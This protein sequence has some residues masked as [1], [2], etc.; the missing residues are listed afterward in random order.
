M[1]VGWSLAWPRT[2]ARLPTARS[3]RHRHTFTADGDCTERVKETPSGKSHALK[4]FENA[5]FQTHL[6]RNDHV[7]LTL[8][9]RP[10]TTKEMHW[11]NSICISVS[12]TT[13]LWSLT[14]VY[15]LVHQTHTGTFLFPNT[16]GSPVCTTPIG[17]HIHSSKF[18][19]F[20]STVRKFASNVFINE[21]VL[22]NSTGVERTVD[23]D[24]SFHGASA[25]C[26]HNVYEVLLRLEASNEFRMVRCSETHNS[27][28]KMNVQGSSV[29]RNHT[30]L[31][32][33]TCEPCQRC[34]WQQYLDAP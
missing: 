10:D 12:T 14:R 3:R 5:P 21:V 7:S 32:D 33:C 16:S 9:R 18:G 29:L 8:L 15:L 22:G 23:D 1:T 34:A 27:Q 30:I 4:C 13:H 31:R 26:L 25:N 2:T 20:D 19:P 6:E 28:S 24:F 17:S 11:R